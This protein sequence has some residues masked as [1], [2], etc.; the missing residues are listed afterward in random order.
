[1]TK[2]LIA[3][4][5]DPQCKWRQGI[6]CLVSASTDEK[7]NVPKHEPYAPGDFRP[8]P[9]GYATIAEVE[10]DTFGLIFLRDAIKRCP[11]TKACGAENVSED[12]IR[13]G[14]AGR[15]VVNL[16]KDLK[17]DQ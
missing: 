6:E 7:T 8:T 1:M 15:R 13:R 2:T 12:L 11:G 17:G 14:N 3:V 10:A 16:I 9:E 5:C 4:D